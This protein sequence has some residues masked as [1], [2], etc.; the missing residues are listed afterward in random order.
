MNEL[1][2]EQLKNILDFILSHPAEKE[3]FELKKDNFDPITL[4]KN[5]SG[6]MN[7]LIRYDIARGYIVWGIDDVSHEVVGTSFI[8]DLKKYKNEELLF[9]LTKNI[10][11]HPDLSF[12]TLEYRNHPVVILVINIIPTAISK[13]QGVALIRI[14]SNTTELKNYPTIEKEIWQKVFSYDYESTP[15]KSNLDRL[16]VEEYLDFNAMYEM[17]LRGTTLE[18]E[19]LFDEA[20]NCGIVKANKDSTYDITNLGALLYARNLASFNNLSSKS[21]RVIEYIGDSRLET[22]DEYR[23]TGGYLVEFNKVYRKIMDSL[24]DH[25]EIGEDGIRKMVYRFPYMTI[26]ELLANTLMHQDFTINELHP[27]VEIFSNR[28]EFTNAGKSLVP[29]DRLVDFPPRTRNEGIAK[30]FYNARISESRGTGWDKIAATSPAFGCPTPQLEE[31]G[32]SVR[33]TLMG[34]RGL[35]AMT[36]D[37]KMRTI[38]YYACFLWVSKDYLTNQNLRKIFRLQDKD[39]SVA[40]RL[41]SQAVE[42]KYL[43]IFD[44]KSSPRDRKYLPFYAED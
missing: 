2:D 15:A 18:K 17:R 34:R 10:T 7:S 4:A 37:E 19:M 5:I 14:G 44:P 38:Y 31:F 29:S 16:Q 6:I 21:L 43:K 33:V 24:A 13:F 42:E 8:P 11:P 22:K 39:N 25:E 23:M 36:F 41:L 32:N 20:I 9:W 35:N 30:E 27:M 28:V 26:R 3:W 40:S 1:T 12:R